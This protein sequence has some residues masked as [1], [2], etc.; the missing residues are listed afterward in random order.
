[1]RGLFM[2]NSETKE[3]EGVREFTPASGVFFYNPCFESL[4]AKYLF[5]YN[6]PRFDFNWLEDDIRAIL[7]NTTYKPDKRN[8]YLYEP[9]SRFELQTPGYEVGGMPLENRKVELV[10][11]GFNLVANEVSWKSVTGIV[12]GWAIYNNTTK[13]RRHKY[14]IA[15][16]KF[17]K[18]IEGDGGWFNIAWG[19]NGVISLVA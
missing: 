15:F 11:G 17:S 12:G 19:E 2:K 1:M 5:R 18:P 16:G 8:D 6:V 10:N 4:L 13:D 3:E 9:I 14:M 7:F